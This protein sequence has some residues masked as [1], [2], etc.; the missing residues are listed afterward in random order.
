MM[1]R[2]CFRF[3]FLLFSI[4]LIRIEQSFSQNLVPNPSFENYSTCPNDLKQ[5]YFAFPWFQPNTYLNAVDYFN[6]CTSNSSIDIPNNWAG[7]QCP[8]TGLA[9]SGI[10]CLNKNNS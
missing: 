9:Y 10:S 2:E 3:I 6:S 8:H 7:Y 1:R 5:I 4:P